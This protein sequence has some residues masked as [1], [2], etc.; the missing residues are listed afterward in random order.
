MGGYVAL[1]YLPNVFLGCML[2]MYVHLILLQD[3]VFFAE[4]HFVRRF[5]FRSVRVCFHLA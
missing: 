4:Q 5:I 1:R 2:Y 3:T